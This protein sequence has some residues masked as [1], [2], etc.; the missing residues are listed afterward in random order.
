[1][2]FHKSVKSYSWREIIFDVV[3]FEICS[4]VVFFWGGGGV[5]YVTGL[6]ARLDGRLRFISSF[7]FL[8]L[9]RDVVACKKGMFKMV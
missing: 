3:K 4:K 6:D 9:S 2:N 5:I 1:M 7:D 8:S